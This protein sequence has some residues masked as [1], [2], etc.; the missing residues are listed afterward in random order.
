VLSCSVT[1]VIA[2]ASEEPRAATTAIS[3]NNDP[4]VGSARLA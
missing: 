1:A 2:Y 3:G 4:S